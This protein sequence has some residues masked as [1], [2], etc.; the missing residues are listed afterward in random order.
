MSLAPRGK[1]KTKEMEKYIQVDTSDDEE[2]IGGVKETKQVKIDQ[3]LFKKSK[4]YSV[5]YSNIFEYLGNINQVDKFDFG[6]I[7]GTFF[8]TATP[9]D[10]MK[11]S[12]FIKGCN[13]IVSQKFVDIITSFGVRKYEFSIKPIEIENEKYY[14]LFVPSISL[15][16][17]NF[18]ESVIYRSILFDTKPIE[19]LKIRDSDAFKTAQIDHTFISFKRIVLNSFGENRNK[20]IIYIPKASPY[21]FFKKDLFDC[22]VDFGITNFIERPNVHIEL[23][24]KI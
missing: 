13:Y 9:T 3:E 20:N 4:F 7:K 12:P 10:I 6:D 17:I 11:F 14:L 8:D 15:N 24:I 2:I 16:H 1:L 18:N 23:K 19:F 21:L 5:Y 22:L